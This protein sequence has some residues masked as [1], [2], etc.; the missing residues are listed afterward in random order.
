MHVGM[1][2]S[3]MIAHD[4]TIDVL[5]SSTSII[6]QWRKLCLDEVAGEDGGSPNDVDQM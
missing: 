4:C 3:P 1:V 5:I 2:L 6:G